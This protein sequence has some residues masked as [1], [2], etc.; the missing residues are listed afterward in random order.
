LDVHRQN[1]AD[2]RNRTGDADNAVRAYGCA[3]E[4]YFESLRLGHEIISISFRLDCRAED[5]GSLALP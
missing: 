4:F 2:E 3:K 1:E 5:S